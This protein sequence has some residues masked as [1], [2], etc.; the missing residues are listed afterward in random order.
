MDKGILLDQDIYKILQNLGDDEAVK[1]I[2]DK[3]SIGCQEKVISKTFFTNNVEKIQNILDDQKTID[4]ICINLGVSIEISKEKIV[5]KLK[6]KEEDTEE[7]VAKNLKIISCPAPNIKKL[8]V[9]DFV[10]YFRV[11]FTELKEI[12]QTR[13]ELE[14]LTSI[15]KI[16]GDRQGV[17]II[18]MVST[19]RVTKNKNILLTLEDLTGKISVLINNNKPVYEKAK[20]ILLDDII[21]VKGS[22]S[23][24][25]LFA[26]DIIYP[27][28]ILPEKIGIDRDEYAAFIA[29]IHLG[30]TN[31]LEENFLKFISWLNGEMG[32]EKQKLEAKKIKYLFITGD[33]VDGVGVF[34]GQEELLSI[35]DVKEQ[36]DQL[37]YY[38]SKI[39]KDV[40]IIMAPGQHDAVRVAEPQPILDRKYAEAIY[41]LDN[42]VLVTNPSMVEIT[43][44]GKRGLRVLMYHG[45]SM[46][47][48]ITE[49]DYLRLNKGHDTPAKVVKEMLVRR[50]LAPIHSS[51]TYIPNDKQDFLAIREV[52]DVITTADLHRTDI[53]TYN[54]ILIICSS[55]WQSM[56][57]F[58]EKVGNNPDPCK[59]PVL[60]LKTRA[61]KILDFS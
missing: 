5:P 61:I 27:D 43:N 8:K 2:I 46:H 26:N 22:G 58:E 52:P 60:N 56:T 47:H 7:V 3:I 51:V 24:E 30:S 50:H 48:F 38:F 23:K 14:N 21:G 34:P 1:E 25:I 57:P 11:R 55:C 18:G 36:Y 39:R 16:S 4:K 6:K 54:N 28:I 33:S 42:V 32:D 29:D 13:P 12:L 45:A 59:V 20:N 15:N 9:E 53:D 17:S 37:A 44:N 40:T 10:K 19:K 35:K 49:I 31:F 41:T